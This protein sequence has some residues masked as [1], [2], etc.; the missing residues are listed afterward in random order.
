MNEG[1]HTYTQH[2]TH[3]LGIPK[4]EEKAE[5]ISRERKTENFQR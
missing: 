2:N 5:A 1:I 3:T 4:D